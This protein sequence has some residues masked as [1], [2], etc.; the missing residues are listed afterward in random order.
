MSAEVW[1][2]LRKIVREA[3]QL[4]AE[5]RVVGGDIEIDGALPSAM[6]RVLPSAYLF[7]YFG[8]ARA[9][10]EAVAFLSQLGVSPVLVTDLAGADAVMAELTGADPIG[11]DIETAPPN[12]R[13]API[14]INADGSVAARQPE[15]SGDGLDPHRATIAS[16]QLYG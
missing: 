1:V 8:A 2:G 10:N 7:Q 6:L 13:P 4:G 12:A 3:H 15:P 14:R 5:F 16:V 9:D 11:L